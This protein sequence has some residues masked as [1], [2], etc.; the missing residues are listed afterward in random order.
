MER[1]ASN[2]L[3]IL[4]IVVTSVVTLAGCLVLL[5]LS[6]CAWSGGSANSQK[7][8]AVAFLVGALV[9]LV[10]S[11]FVIA[12]LAKG[13]AHSG[14]LP[15]A[16][17]SL[18]A[19]P[20]AVEPLDHISPA[21]QSAIRQLVFAIIVLIVVSAIHTLA[22]MFWSGDKM[23]LGVSGAAVL[24]FLYQFPYAVLLVALLR[25]RARHAF[26]YAI[27]IPLTS[28]IFS[29]YTLPRALPYFYAH[30]PE[31]L[32]FL[33]FSLALEGAVLWMAW[34][35]SQRIGYKHQSGF[36]SIAGVVMLLYFGLLQ[37]VFVP[38]LVRTLW[39]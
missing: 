33:I 31:Q 12:K 35:A 17:P 27:V 38:L 36:L 20:P 4:G 7:G 3:R 15:V 6:L 25:T 37:Y 39:R 2:T 28:I 21:S 34:R 13:V 19:N 22:N 10:L 5:L 8:A 11:I 24:F 26:A 29:L 30:A 23:G 14:A 16:S 1:W 32:V 9:V 18:I